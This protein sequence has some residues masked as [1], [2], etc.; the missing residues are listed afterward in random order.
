MQPVQMC[1]LK[2]INLCS[3][4]L[5]LASLCVLLNL[6]ASNNSSIEDLIR[7]FDSCSLLHFFCI[8]SNTM[9]VLFLLAHQNYSTALFRKSKISLALHLTVYGLSPVVSS[10]NIIC[11]TYKGI[12]SCYSLNELILVLMIFRFFC[13]YLALVQFTKYFDF[14]SFT[15]LKTIS[16]T[17]FAC[18]CVYSENKIIVT[19]FTF[20]AGNHLCAYLLTIFERREG[21]IALT[22][23]TNANWCAFISGFTIG[24]GDLFPYTLLGRFVIVFWIFFGG[25]FSW[26]FIL[27]AS[28]VFTMNKIEFFVYKDINKINKAGKF[29]NR[30]LAGMDFQEAKK[31][32]K[33]ELERQ[34][35]S[36]FNYGTF[37]IDIFELPPHD[38]R[39]TFDRINQL[40]KNLDSLYEAL[41][42]V[43]LK[44]TKLFNNKS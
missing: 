26:Y 32:F 33:E 39:T 28:N 12:D 3:S 30:C 4:L 23:I 21:N 13:F 38:Y 2:I 5:G 19:F 41:N 14:F 8:V 11:I 24:T 27:A 29:I 6:Y 7:G 20:I 40:D 22:N 34:Y 31:E 44:F 9:S 16:P 42:F 10:D 37:I 25:A 36:P 17:Y 35:K 1:E 15:G 18:K 43:S